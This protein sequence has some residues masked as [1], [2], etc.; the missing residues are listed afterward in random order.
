MQ[1]PNYFWALKYSTTLAGNI[2]WYFNLIKYSMDA[3]K[4]IT[5]VIMTIVIMILWTAPEDFYDSD[6]D[7][8]ILQYKCAIINDY[9]QVPN[10]VL[11][12]CKSI[13]EL[14]NESLR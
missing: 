5:I 12:E 7:S 13:K 11:A 1:K 2:H 14:Q 3:L 10:E 9:E 6:E 8:V 4:N